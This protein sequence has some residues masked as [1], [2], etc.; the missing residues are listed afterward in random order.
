MLEENTQMELVKKLSKDL[1]EATKIL[2][3][4]EARYLVDYY[5]QMQDFRIQANNQKRKIK[6]SAEN[7]N[8]TTSPEKAELYNAE[9]NGVIDFFGESFEILE[10]QLK[11]ALGK[12][13][14]S[15]PIGEWLQSICGIGPVISAGLISHID[16]TKVQT[17]GQIQKFAGQCPGAD[18]SV[19][20]Q[21][22]VFNKKLKTLC[23]KLG[24]SFVKVQN[25]PKD[26]YGK[27]YVLR[28]NY[29]QEKNEQLEYKEQADEGAKRVGKSTEAYKYY[30]EGKLPPGHIQRRAERYAV[31]IFLSHLFEVWYIIENGKEPPAPFPIAI[32]GH[33]HK[34]EPPRIEE[35]KA[36]YLK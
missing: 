13:A 34:V 14:A 16:I 27:I 29:E 12:Y 11:Y 9:P 8:I 26:V 36:K 22:N 17:A 32:L 15:K 24:Q 2:S 20:G 6:S 23:W 10:N 28:K 4:V 19:A 7:E 3:D 30:I 35:I 21:R 25:N 18:R 31:K 5:Y 1:R 33:A